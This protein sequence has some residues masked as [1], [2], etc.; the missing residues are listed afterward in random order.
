MNTRRGFTLQSH[1]RLQGLASCPL[2]LIEASRQAIASRSGFTLIELILYVTLTSM[3]MTGAVLFAWNVVYSREKFNQQQL[4]EDEGTLALGRIA[5][6]IRRAKTI[7][8]LT[9]D[10]IILNDEGGGTTTIASSSGNIYI[11]TNGGGPYTLIGNQVVVTET[12]FS[13]ATSPN[14]NSSHIKVRIA[15]KQSSTILST[16]T[17][18]H[19]AM[20]QSVELNSQFNQA[21]GLLMDAGDVRLTVGNKHIENTFLE[22][23]GSDNITINTMKLSWTGG[24]AGSVLQTIIINGSTVWSGTANSGDLLDITNVTLV[25]GAG[26]LPIDVIDFSKSMANAV[27]TV[28]FGMTDSST[29][30]TEILLGT[31]PTSTPTPTGT[32]T[33]TLTPTSTLTPTATLTPTSTLTP[34]PTPANCNE[35]CQQT[36]TLP[37]SCIKKNVCTGY[38]EGK[39]YECGGANVCCC[40]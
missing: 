18:A 10:Q 32:G 35:H 28:T 33:P 8:S 39:I 34:T 5:Y 16:Q 3:F 29:S 7:Q 20:S 37:G 26:A 31:A 19:T 21:R 11:T 17:L 2:R 24:D 25:T 38:D 22:N 40:E 4:V 12:N 23:S 14:N 15:L 13:N 1:M 6:E 30:N 36:Y 27:I 9:S